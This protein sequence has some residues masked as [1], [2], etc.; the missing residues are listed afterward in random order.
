MLIDRQVEYNPFR[1]KEINS[2]EWDPWSWSKG[3]CSPEPGNGAVAKG[4]RRIETTPLVSNQ[5]PDPHWQVS[6]LSPGLEHL[7]Q[8]W[9]KES[10][11]FAVH[12]N[13]KRPLWKSCA[14][15]CRHCC[16]GELD[17]HTSGASNWGWIAYWRLG[18]LVYNFQEERPQC[19]MV[20][21]EFVLWL[22]LSLALFECRSLKT[23]R[24][25]FMQIKTC[26]SPGA[27]RQ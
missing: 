22:D 2:N 15:R 3:I 6:T 13:V 24:K 1:M 7:L 20:E 11:E 9:R 17:L 25:G 10:L 23:C 12:W 19:M 14:R 18:Y 26:N 5:I 16:G 4:H 8:R 27:Y 21:T